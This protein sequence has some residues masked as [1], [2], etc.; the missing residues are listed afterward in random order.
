MNRLLYG[1]LLAAWITGASAVCAELGGDGLP[2]LIAVPGVPEEKRT[3]PRAEPT[4]EDSLEL[5][6]I[7]GMDTNPGVKPKDPP[8]AETDAELQE[9]IP[10]P[11]A[12]SLEVPVIEEEPKKPVW[13]TPADTLIIE[14][15][16]A[17][18]VPEPVPVDPSTEAP[19][20]PAEIDI[21]PLP[22][23]EEPLPPTITVTEEPDLNVGE[24][25]RVPTPAITHAVPPNVDSRTVAIL[26][27]NQIGSQELYD[28]LKDAYGREV[29]R[30]LIDRILL[31]EELKRRGIQIGADAIRRAYE[32]HIKA[33]AR[34]AGQKI[35]PDSFLRYHFGLSSAEYKDR[36]IWTQL[37]LRRL[38][39]K[40]MAITDADL[41]NYYWSSRKRY[42][43]PEEVRAWHILVDPTRFSKKGGEGARS[44]GPA[45]WQ[46]AQ[47]YALSIV[48]R[49]QGG[50]SFKALAKSVSHD[51]KSAE[52]NGDLGFL[53]RG[54]MAR[55]FEEAAFGLALGSVSDPVKTVFGYHIIMVTD[56]TKKQLKPFASVKESVREDYEEYLT[57]TQAASVLDRLRRAAFREGRLKVLD[58][59]LMPA[60]GNSP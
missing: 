44:A 22:K 38:V 30:Q 55:P 6:V 19:P 49:I 8:L 34:S 13:P 58:P 17:K 35:Q 46:A 47:R 24:R 52:R 60:S 26:G 40:E 50:E 4:A 18:P 59:D 23:E 15:R 31:R 27:K 41:F 33:F 39:E 51:R 21:P 2:D 42:T 9:I 29:L 16:T 10:L 14:D 56:R 45:E 12:E 1:T 11:N 53:P 7:P 32:D 57:K 5:P 36:V 48:K 20:P 25:P 43:S 3:P 37:A 28:A 54:M